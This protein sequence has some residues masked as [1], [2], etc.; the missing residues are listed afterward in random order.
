M[1]GDLYVHT[2]IIEIEAI[3][4]LEAIAC[5]MIPVIADSRKSATKKFA[6]D[7]RCLYKSRNVQDLADHIDYW[8]EHKEEKASLRAKYAE[9][10]KQFD[11]EKCMNNMEKMLVEVKENYAKANQK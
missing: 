5:G 8:F 4:C 7:E 9:F 10:I 6:L 2:S 3:S 11:F 1:C